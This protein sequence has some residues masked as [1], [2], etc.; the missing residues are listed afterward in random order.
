MHEWAL[1]DAVVTSVLDAVPGRDARRIRSVRL[2][3]GELQAVDREIFLF[4]LGVLLEPYGITAE[5]FVIETQRAEMACGAC[6][7]T[8]VMGEDPGLSEEQREAIHF[9]PEAAHAFVRCPRCGGAD[10]SVSAGRGVSIGGI[11]LEGGA[12]HS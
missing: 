5:R 1:A 7:H 2:L 3:I 6:G 4:G 10:F 9:L 12:G 11:E 8:W